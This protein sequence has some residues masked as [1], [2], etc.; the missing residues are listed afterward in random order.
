MFNL[1][2]SGVK[3]KLAEGCIKGVANTMKDPH[4]RKVVGVFVGSLSI[5]LGI[6]LGGSLIVS[7]YV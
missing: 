3:I 6:G 5:G 1:I 7:S 4:A 2:K